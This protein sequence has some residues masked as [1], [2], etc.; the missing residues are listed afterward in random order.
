MYACDVYCLQL[1]ATTNPL[2]L[3]KQTSISSHY[4]LD[5]MLSAKDTMTNK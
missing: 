4:E 2:I 5:L 3:Q 1:S